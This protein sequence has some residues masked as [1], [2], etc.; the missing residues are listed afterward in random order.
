MKKILAII[1]FSLY[2]SS[3]FAE[4]DPTS[5]KMKFGF[6]YNKYDINFGSFVFKYDSYNLF[7]V[8]K[9]SKH[10][11]LGM[12][13]NLHQ[14]KLLL[15]ENVFNHGFG[16]QSN[17]QLLPFIIKSNKFR[18]DTYII[19]R[20]GLLKLFKDPKI[21]P[22]GMFGGGIVFYP[23]KH[24]GLLSEYSAEMNTYN[25]FKKSFSYLSWKSF[26]FGFLLKF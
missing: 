18:F 22:Y 12:F 7:S 11:E 4:E 10:F 5:L 9:F 17:I 6:T 19:L 13:Y 20:L 26:K 16:F 3:L 15:S 14:R 2:V 24:I 21:H 8:R 23:F 25:T 1:T